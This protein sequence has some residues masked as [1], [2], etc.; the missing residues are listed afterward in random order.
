MGFAQCSR[1]GN[2]W[3]DGIVPFTISDTDFPPG[4]SERDEILAGIALWNLN[5]CIRVVPRNGQPNGLHFIKATDSCSS[6]VGQK[7]EATGAPGQSL[8]CAVQLDG[9]GST[10]IT[11]EV[12]H[13]L[14][15]LHEQQRPDRDTFVSIN[16]A[17]IDLPEDRVEVNFDVVAD[18]C[19]IGPYD[20]GSIMHYGPTAFGRKDGGGAE[21]TTI[22]PNPGTGCTSIGQ[23]DHLSAGDV[24]T[25]HA[26]YGF[27]ELGYEGLSDK[28]TLG[29]TSDSSPTL[30]SHGGRLF[31]AWRGESNE[32]LNLMF[33]EDGGLS[34]RGKHVFGDTSTDTPMLASHNGRL[35][36]AWKGSGNEDLNVAEVGL[37]P[38]DGSV[39]I[40]GLI[41]KRT[42]SER[43]DDAP[44][45]ASHAGRLYI[46]WR[47]RPNEQLNVMF[48]DD[49]GLT[50]LGKAVFGDSTTSTPTLSSHDGRL[51]IAWKGSGNDQLNIA[52]VGVGPVGG[53]TGITGL[54]NKAVLSETSDMGPALASHGNRLALS[55]QGQ[56]NENV[57]VLSACARLGIFSSGVV[58]K[59]VSNETTSDAP[60]LTSHNNRLFVA[61]KG[62]GNE[63][64]NIAKVDFFMSA[65]APLKIGV[66]IP[67][68]SGDFVQSTYGHRGN[69]ELVVPQQRDLV[70]YFRDNE[71]PSAP[72]S[73]AHVLMSGGVQFVKD[74][75]S[76]CSCMKVEPDP[77]QVSLIQSNFG[78]PANLD[79]VV[80]VR[81]PFGAPEE[82]EDTLVTF[83]FDARSG[84]WGGP[85]PLLVEREIVRGVTGNPALIQSTFGRKGNF[86]LLVPQRGELVHFW[87]NNDDPSLPWRRG[88][89]LCR[90]GSSFAK[91]RDRVVREILLDPEP[92]GVALLQSSLERP[93]NL[94]AVVRMRTASR[95]SSVGGDT[96]VTFTFDS[97]ALKWSGPTPI[98]VGR[99]PISGVT[100]NP[101]F[102]QSSFG[103]WGNFEL[104]VPQG[105]VVMHYSRDNDTTNPEW[106]QVG[107]AYNST[108]LFR[109]ERRGDEHNVG[110]PVG[111]SMIQSR[112]DEPGRLEAIIRIRTSAPVVPGINDILVYAYFD[113]RTRS[114]QG[115]F[116]IEAF[117]KPIA[118]V[119]TI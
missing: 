40:T 56:S 106:R 95:D 93:G 57:N 81:T 50:F 68:H 42:L 22:T 24:K 15:L 105:R 66:P 63:N 45:L 64:L 32:Q 118:G 29:E 11:H 84:A 103:R 28:V 104:L 18:E 69:F 47:G 3:P 85:M 112:L 60:G 43:S 86:E 101:A 27:P 48:S 116:P 14:G 20:C 111:V 39:N 98:I 31:L 37:T 49:N 36:I 51:F 65:A 102:L 114:W 90:G 110:Y 76:Q 82:R 38:H 91:S 67:R 52:E 70:H 9:F 55:W 96:L 100:G 89:V 26:I 75:E 4:S 74:P 79:L 12:G 83:F 62:S 109:S 44:S 33:S 94:E 107:V 73:R 61:W 7:P 80:R 58:A 46:A 119:V 97:R 41:N 87:R 117:G 16:Y 108:I 5:T 25:I 71:P 10:S 35:L 88:A 54:F 115:P 99:N 72:W 1:A 59:G 21:A 53:G 34:F 8:S 78:K 77:L 113:P 13:A 23:R 2:R 17:N 19:P 6:A 30:A 92:I